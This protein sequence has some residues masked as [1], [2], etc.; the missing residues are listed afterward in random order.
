MSIRSQTV[1]RLS[2][3]MYQDQR[4]TLKGEIKRQETIVKKSKPDPDII[5][6][7]EQKYLKLN[8]GLPPSLLSL[9]S[10]SLPV[11][12]LIHPP[13]LSPHPSPLPLS[14]SGLL[15]F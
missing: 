3:Q 9:S 10:S 12:R 6:K 5:D 14:S 15:A 4:S 11:F 8:E 2:T 13:C 7:L 1:N